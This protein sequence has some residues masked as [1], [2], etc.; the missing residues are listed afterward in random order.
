MSIRVLT[1][2]VLM[3]LLV[4]FICGCSSTK[5]SPD[6]SGSKSTS[7]QTG[8]AKTGSAPTADNCASNR[9]KCLYKGS[10]DP[11]ERE[12]AEEEA[13]RLNLAEYER[14]RRSMGK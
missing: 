2:R 10:Y 13:K 14:L 4:A 6:A 8:S 1:R 9:K 7:A 5:T 3:L 11:G 12:Y